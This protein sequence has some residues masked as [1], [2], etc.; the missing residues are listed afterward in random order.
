MSFLC[1]GNLFYML[2]LDTNNKVKTKYIYYAHHIYIYEDCR[3]IKNIVFLTSIFAIN[4]IR[5][6]YIDGNYNLKFIKVWF[7]QEDVYM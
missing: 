3:V 5:M 6:V 2:I 1:L 7:G 4:I